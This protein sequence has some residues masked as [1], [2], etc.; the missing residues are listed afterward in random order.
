[1]IT[2]SYDITETHTWTPLTFESLWLAVREAKGAAGPDAYTGAELKIMPIETIR[3]FHQCTLRWWSTG[4]HQFRQARQINLCEPHKIAN[5]RIAVGDLR[6]LA[7]MTCFWRTYASA[8]ARS[9][10][11]RNWAKTH[12]HAQVSHGKGAAGAEALAEE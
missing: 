4:T 3:D 2:S 10:Q 1:M 8:W 6:P 12:F 5:G 9:S 11:L 7:V